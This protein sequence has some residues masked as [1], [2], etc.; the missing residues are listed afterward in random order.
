MSA[1]P[2]E[3]PRQYISRTVHK[4]I[5]LRPQ[6][7]AEAKRIAEKFNLSSVA[8]NVVAARGYKADKKLKDYLEPTLKA[9]LPDPKELRNLESACQTIAQVVK[10][11]GAIAICCDF[12]VDGLSGGSQVYH[13]LRSVGAKVRV[14][15]PDRFNEGYGL[16]EAVVRQIAADGFA[17]LLTIDF[18]TTNTKELE[19]AKKLG[20]KTIVL[21][22]H[23][24]TADCAADIFIN[25]EHESCGFA[26]RV[27][28]SAGLSW[29]LL[30][31]LKD[32][33]TESK[34]ID[35][36]NYLDLACLGTICDMVPLI[37]ANRVIAK[38][39]LELLTQ[40]ERV[41][42][43]ALKAVASINNEVT[44]YHV[45]FGIGPRLNAAGRMVHGEIVVELLTTDDTK[46]AKK[47]AEK[48]DRLNTQRK[49]V[50]ENIRL[51]AKEQIERRGEI[52]PGLVVWDKD[53]HTGVIGI[54]AQ[55]LIEDFY[56]PTVV[57]GM[58]KPGVFKGSVRGI[59]GFSVVDA[60]AATSK[61]L[62]K[63]G[64]HQGA[65][66]LSV[67]ERNLEQFRE[68][69][70]HEC[71]ER[72]KSLETAPYATADTEVE[73]VDLRPAL[74]EE[75]Q[76]FAPFGMGNPQPQ[77]LV[78]NL[79]VTDIRL[80]K[81]AHLK[82]TLSNGKQSLDGIMWRKVSHPA[83][84]VGKRVNVVFKPDVN[85]YGGYAQVQANLQAI[86]EASF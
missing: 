13:F 67:E 58:D 56:R 30:I 62:I 76:S 49:D 44:C 7:E 31:G 41:G 63:F 65:G 37:G 59:S 83:L 9:G 36:K 64:G 6:N 10:S 3:A 77:L 21:D 24:T 40:T 86:E 47:L 82:A 71:E 35:V 60:L 23:H 27:M 22:H 50:E 25:P 53:F 42:L 57:L 17:L 1:D 28:C 38:R 46:L 78:K 73:V 20:L 26:E 75:L 45:G 8:A 5:R 32:H 84:A 80:L 52:L 74:V 14:F 33:F 61:H 29:Y 55:R 48:L 66:G 4:Q 51:R 15:V 79:K 70:V 16:H 69:W 43:Q 72:L 18:G 12:D 54:V 68:A 11:G 81:G 39:G 2:A 19:L 34:K 85:A